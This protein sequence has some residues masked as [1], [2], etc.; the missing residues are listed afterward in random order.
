[1][2]AGRAG[3]GR[4]IARKAKTLGIASLMQSNRLPAVSAFHANSGIAG[5]SRQTVPTVSL[6]IRS[7][8]QPPALSEQPQLDRLFAM[9]TLDD[10]IHQ[11]LSPAR[12]DHALLAPGRFR[13]ILMATR[14]TVLTQAAH[15]RALA[16]RL[17]T[18]ASLLDEQDE[19]CRLAQLYC[20]ALLQG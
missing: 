14:M 16:R 15:R 2:A 18:L 20:A 11:R 13:Q 7:E 6:P 8:V 3:N 19:L 12:L 1:M 17:G 4:C 9:V 10:Y 5:I